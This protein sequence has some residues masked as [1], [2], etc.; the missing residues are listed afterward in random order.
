VRRRG[1]RNKNLKKRDLQLGIIHL[2]I[3]LLLLRVP[4]EEPRTHCGEHKGVRVLRT[5]G[6]DPS[7]LTA[8]NLDTQPSQFEFVGVGSRNFV[9]HENEIR[10]RGP[11]TFFRKN[12]EIFGG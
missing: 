3:R 5:V 2:G 11:L 4:A 9:E 6:F 8:K 10:R 7:S 1:K 12:R